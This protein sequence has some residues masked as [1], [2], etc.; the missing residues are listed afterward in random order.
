MENSN[1]VADDDYEEADEE[2]AVIDL[3]GMY[4]VD[5]Y[6]ETDLVLGKVR[7]D[8]IHRHLDGLSYNYDLNPLSSEM[9]SWM[10]WIP[11][12][13][14]GWTVKYVKVIDPVNNRALCIFMDLN[15]CMFGCVRFLK[16][17]NETN[18]TAY[19]TPSIKRDK[20]NGFS[21]PKHGLMLEFDA[22]ERFF[23]DL[24]C[25]PIV[26]NSTKKFPVTYEP[27]FSLKTRDPLLNIWWV[28]YPS[29]DR[30]RQYSPHLQDHAGEVLQVLRH[31][32]R[33]HSMYPVHDIGASIGWEQGP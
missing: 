25:S 13:H 3:D 15:P 17:P 30:T 18:R 8:R 24:D 28:Y 19:I 21:S 32:S 6:S 4:D 2:A 11:D 31:P 1:E 16:D 5:E 27:T 10:Q 26:R 14:D 33:L 23:H 12:W 20:C 9:T 29:S 22:A 7:S